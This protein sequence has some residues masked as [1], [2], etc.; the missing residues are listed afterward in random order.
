MCWIRIQAQ[1][2]NCNTQLDHNTHIITIPSLPLDSFTMFVILSHREGMHKLK[3]VQPYCSL[4]S[5]FYWS[6]IY[7]VL[8]Q[9]HPFSMLTLLTQEATHTFLINSGK[10]QCISWYTQL[11]HEVI[12]TKAVLSVLRWTHWGAIAVVTPCILPWASWAHH[13]PSEPS[14]I[15]RLVHHSQAYDAKELIRL[16]AIDTQTTVNKPLKTA[17]ML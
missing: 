7:T 10:S 3:P 15:V 4:W 17:E 14:S 16:S 8:S 13:L 9:V 12:K 2:S 5:S 11:I 6:F 1:C